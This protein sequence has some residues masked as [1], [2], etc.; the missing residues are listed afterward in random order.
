MRLPFRRLSRAR[1]RRVPVTLAGIALLASVIAIAL[2]SSR[3]VAGAADRAG[4][5]PAAWTN[6]L[7]PIS[8]ADWGYDLAAHL[9]ERAGFGAT[10]EEIDRLAAMTPQQVVDVLVDYEKVDNSALRPFDQSPIWD[11]GMDPFPE[12]RAEAVRIARA[13]GEGLGEKLLPEGTPRR[14]QPVVNK[15]FYGLR[16][17]VLETQ[18]LA[19]WWANRML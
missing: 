12:S 8:R 15:F 16:A 7:A 5:G 14:L 11:R 10:P 3:P 9:I 18:R 19:L 13:R 1:S 6:D 4:A 17:N 2:A